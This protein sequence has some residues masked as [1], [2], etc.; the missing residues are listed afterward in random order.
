MKDQYHENR[1]VAGDIV[2]AKVNP[3]L[4]L[5]VR[6][7]IDRIYYCKIMEQPDKKELVYFERE[8]MIPESINF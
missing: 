7:Y 1:Y 4:K 2:Y 3:S 6:R 8:L 5:I